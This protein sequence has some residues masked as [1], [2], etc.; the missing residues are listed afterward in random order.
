V[1]LVVIGLNHRTTPVEL[2]ERM[3]VPPPELAKALHTL[4]RSDNLDEVAV[5]STCNRTEVYARCTRFHPAVEDVRNFLTD[6]SGLDPDMITDHLYTYHDDAAVAHLFGVAA[7]VDSMIVGEG[8]ILGQVREAWQVAEREGMIGQLLSR[9]FHQ[10]VEVGKRARTETGIGRHAV[11]VSSAAVAV[12]GER[13]GG[14]E[15]R[16]V[17]VVGAGDV[18]TGMA[19]ALNGAGVGEIVVANRS[20]ERADELAARVG[21]RAIG[22][23][24]VRD[25]LVETDVLLASTGAPDVL[26]ERSEI[27]SAMSRRDGRA[28]LIVDIAVPRNVDP[29]VGQVFGVTLLDIDGLKAFAAQSLAQRR[30]EIG[31]VREIITEELDKFRLERSAREVAPLISSMRARAEELRGFELERFRSRLAG[32]DDDERDAV[33]A[34]TRGLVNKL[35]H[36]PT[37]RV[38]DAAGTARGEVYADA[39]AALFGLEDVSDSASGPEPEAP[40]DGRGGGGSADRRSRS[41]SLR[42][43]QA[44]P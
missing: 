13:L 21:G 40:A 42:G 1:S 16:R 33:D 4:E 3:A 44:R 9:V 38:K 31:K 10:S 17:L 23:D 11:S 41:P 29:G 2:L 37:V 14:L 19:I 30:Q 25:G 18:G 32:L 8:E 5:L 20:P 27:E 26:L 39:L 34:L 6:Q 43:R 28:L 24:A 36:D 7:G 35:L 15:N 22:L 12:A